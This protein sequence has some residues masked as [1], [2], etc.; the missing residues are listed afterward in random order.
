ML[1]ELE[2]ETGREYQLTSAISAAKAKIDKID[3]GQVQKSVDHFYDEL[4]L[5]GAFDLN[6][7][8]YQTALNASSWRPD[9]EYTTVNGVNALLNQGVDPAKIVVGAAM[10][11]RG[12]TG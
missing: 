9:T 2:K 4:R 11:G 12:W 10:Y 5:Y 7:L 8:G 1:D 3:F 6:T